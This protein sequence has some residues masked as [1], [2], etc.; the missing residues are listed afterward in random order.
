[1]PI[2]AFINEG[3]VI[4]D[5]LEHLGEPTS[6]PSLAP[7]RGPP[8]WELPVAGQPERETDPQAQPAPDYEF[9][10]RI[11]WQGPTRHVWAWCRGG[12]CLQAVSCADL[13]GFWT[14]LPIDMGRKAPR[15][16]PV[17]ALK[18][19]FVDRRYRNA[20]LSG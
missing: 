16:F 1:M 6:A 3:P 14:K 11:A 5:I 4:R 9:D 20:S 19:L 13:S 15:Y 12:S 10:Q 18:F 2:I 8:L 7:A 17:G